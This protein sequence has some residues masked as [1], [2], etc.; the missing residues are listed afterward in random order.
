APEPAPEPDS[1][2][3]SGSPDDFMEYIVQP[4]DTISEIARLHKVEVAAIIRVNEITN[5]D[6]IMVGKV[7]K[8][9]PG[10]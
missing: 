10:E 2:A 6:R 3:G 1:E 4:G 7:L 9:L 5:P 8:I